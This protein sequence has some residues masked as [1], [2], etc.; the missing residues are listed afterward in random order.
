[1]VKL[2]RGNEVRH[3]DI[4]EKVCSG[5]SRCKGP[6]VGVAWPSKSSSGTRVA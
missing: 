2:C 6:V 1:M 5:S 3:V 4:E